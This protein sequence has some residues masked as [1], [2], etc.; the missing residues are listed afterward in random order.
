MI[1]PLE[2]STMT[3]IPRLLP[4]IALACSMTVSGMVAFAAPKPAKTDKPADAAAP[5]GDPAAPADPAMDKPDKPEKPAKPAKPVKPAKPAPADAADAA[6]TTDKTKAKPAAGDT[7]APATDTPA[8]EIPQN[9]SL[10]DDVDD[11]WHYGKIA[12]YPMA[13]AFGNK[14]LTR[15]EKP[16]EILQAFELTASSHQDGLDDWILRWEGVDANGMKDVATKLQTLLNTGRKERRMLPAYIQENLEALSVNER[17]YAN[18]LPRL[19]DS[20]ELAVPMM[21]DYLKD[22]NKSQFHPAIRRALKQLGRPILNPL[23]AATEMK[24]SEETL[25]KLCDVLGSIGYDIAVPY[26]QKVGQDNTHTAGVREAA[27]SAVRHLG[28]NPNGNAA[29]EFYRLSEKF[30]QNG[31]SISVDPKAPAAY[32]WYWGATGLTYKEVPPAIF[33]DVMAMREAEYSLKLGSGS[34]DALSLWLVANNKVEVDLPEGASAGIFEKD[35]P[36][37]NYYNV[38]AG[39]QY[40]NAA[41][42]RSLEDHNSAVAMKVIKSLAEIV[43]PSSQGSGVKIDPLVESMHY[44]D[45]LVRF[46]AAF[47]LAGSLPNNPFPGHER[48]PSLLCEAVSQTGNA[49]VLIVASSQEEQT[50]LATDLKQYGTAGGT[51]PQLAFNAAMELPAVDVIVMPE[52]LGDQT[53]DQVYQLAAQSA[54]MERVAKIIITKTKAS[55][56]MQRGISD[57]LTVVTQA[58]DAA[59][60]TAAVE[61]ARKRAGGLPLDEKVATAYALKGAETLHRL[62]EGNVK[63]FDLSGTVPSLLAALNDKRPEVVKAVGETLAYLKDDLIQAALL[64]RA[65]DEKTPDDVKV[66][67]LKSLAKQAKFTGVHL[68]GNQLGDLQK[69]VDSAANLDVRTAAAEARGALNLA[70]DQAKQLI[71]KQSKT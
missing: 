62:A 71:I 38:Y 61:E 28:G 19:R 30:Y 63:A 37:A 65:V 52:S 49:N 57:P 50:K 8:P 12:Q 46:E 48:V 14:L 5:A 66:T 70:A 9:Q 64:T 25:L 55:P 44:A 45:R 51:S 18:H 16:L 67:L 39:A 69:Q 1:T 7:P 68:N 10:R 42:T 32:M 34:R 22:P 53:I 35:R 59:G 13:A 4:C 41:L 58:G 56:W 11:F 31:A 6:D 54:R 60:L 36:S 47:A 29:D 3:R 26:L 23:L 20:G 17:S 15:T 21:L 43:G 27:A 33:S 40:L 2:A 24:N